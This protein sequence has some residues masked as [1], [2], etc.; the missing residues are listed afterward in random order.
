MIQKRLSLLLFLSCCAL[1]A[2]REWSLNDCIQYALK[3]NLNLDNEKYNVAAAKETKRQSIRSLLPNIN[4]SSGYNVS[5]GRAI[6]P[7]DNSYVT[8]SFFSNSYNIS[9]SINLFNGFSKWHEIKTNALL[10]Q[11]AQENEKYQRYI[12]A[13]QIMEE[14]YAV[15]YSKELYNL[16]Q[17]IAKSSQTNYQLVSKKLDL[18]MVA[19]TDLYDAK[20][21]LLND[22]LSITQ[23]YNTWQNAK[24]Q[25]L[26]DMNIE[27]AVNNIKFKEILIPI[28]DKKYDATTIYNEASVSFP[29]IKASILGLGASKKQLSIAKAR[30]YPSLYFSA[31]YGSGYYET[32][33]DVS[34]NIIS[35]KEQLQ[36]NAN[37]Y[38]SFS[39]NI[40]ISNAWSTHSAIKQRKIYI[41]QQENEV[42]LSKQAVF[43]AIQQL[44]QEHNAL[45]TEYKRIT[46]ALKAQELTFFSAQK[47]FDKGLIDMILLQKAKEDLQ[48]IQINQLNVKYKLKVNEAYLSIYKGVSIFNDVKTNN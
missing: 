12:L 2:Q 26:Q 27:D 4:A 1:Y 14:F 36:N 46:E 34:G 21:S 3:H 25:L 39:L 37:G 35:F 10:L 44:V 33:E 23:A 13:L 45:L 9:S 31:G 30:L 20:T 22:E 32:R 7:D 28:E 47:K 19:K 11:V 6:N 42:K 48:N 18:G 41:K 38:I 40:P 43:K 8:T 16:Q 15:K 24:L 29:S 17:L 5:Y